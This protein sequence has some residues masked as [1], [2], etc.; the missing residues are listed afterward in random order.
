MLMEIRAKS[1]LIDNLGSEAMM[2]EALDKVEREI[3]KPILRP[4]K[5]KALLMPRLIKSTESK[6]CFRGF[7]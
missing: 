6:Y 4:D 7:Y 3:K 1:G 5:D 2:M